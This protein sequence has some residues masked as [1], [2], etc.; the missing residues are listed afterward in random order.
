[1]YIRE[2][3]SIYYLVSLVFS[4][5]LVEKDASVAEWLRTPDLYRRLVPYMVAQDWLI[6]D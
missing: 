2:Y 6:V 3:R 1:M 4:S 5:L